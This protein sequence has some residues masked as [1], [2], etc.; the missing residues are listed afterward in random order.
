MVTLVVGGTGKV[1]SVAVRHLV[2]KGRAVRVITHSPDKESSIPSGVEVARGDLDKPE[3]IVPAFNGVDE[4]VLVLQVNPNEQ[5]RGLAAVEAAKA[6]GVKRLVFLSLVHGPGTELVPFYQSKLAI[7]AAFKQSDMEWA[8][9]RSS[10]FF[11]SDAGLK[12][13]I[14]NQGVFSAPIGSMGVSRID[15]RDV[16]YAVAEAMTKEPFET[17]E[18]RIFGPEALTGESIAQIYSGLLG[19]SVRYFGD[20]LDEWA[21]FKG[22][23]FPPWSLNALRNMYGAIQKTGMKPE[24]GENKSSLLPRDLITFETFARGLV[25]TGTISVS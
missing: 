7:E 14:L 20:D 22:D 25:S 17:G 18:F 9:V 11:Q 24:E 16:G 4:L 8:V 10:S 19:K 6:A 23:A 2:D 1:G 15:T 21:A 5:A 12:S 13:E 3:T